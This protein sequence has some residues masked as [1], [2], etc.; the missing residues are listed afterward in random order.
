MGQFG[1]TQPASEGLLP[2]IY[3]IPLYR[4]QTSELTAKL[5]G[6]ARA[7]ESNTQRIGVLQGCF[8][9]QVG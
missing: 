3:T 4:L 5:A 2:N 8:C 6:F 9:G 7:S 1:A